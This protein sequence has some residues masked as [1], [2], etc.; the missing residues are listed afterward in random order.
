MTLRV[1]IKR[2]IT[3][4]SSV[5]KAQDSF[6]T[7]DIECPELEEILRKSIINQHRCDWR[8]VFAVEVL[9]ETDEK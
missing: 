5:V 4:D 1:I 7:M 9:P 8:S 2:T 3:E 6:E